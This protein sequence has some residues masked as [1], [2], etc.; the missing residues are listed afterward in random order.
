[1]KRVQQ[2]FTL[3]ELMIV[4]AIIGILAAI[5]LPA[6]QDYMTRTRISEGL[7]LAADAKTLIATGAGSADEL[8]A[9]VTAYNLQ[10]NSTGATSKYVRSV[11][12]AP[13]GGAG[14]P[15]TGEITVTFNGPTVGRIADNSTLVLRPFIR[16]GVNTTTL[17]VAIPAGTSGA[18]DWGCAS[19]AQA[20]ANARGL[21]GITPG[22]L[23][24]RFASAEC[25]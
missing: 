9:A 17:D 1:M 15:S 25:K 22:T 6:Y 18:M 20:V 23:P 8:N 4:V 7:A 11:L 10:A 14:V 16:D 21:N 13:A 3:I 12:I 24:A 2:G 19:D 5:A